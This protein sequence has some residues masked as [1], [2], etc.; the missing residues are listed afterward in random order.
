MFICFRILKKILKKNGVRKKGRAQKEEKCIL[1]LC[2][3]WRA[4][5]HTEATCTL[6]FCFT[7]KLHPSA[8]KTVLIAGHRR[9]K[10]LSNVLILLAVNVI[11]L[12]AMHVYP[13]SKAKG[14]GLRHNSIQEAAETN[15]I[16]RS[17]WIPDEEFRPQN[18]VWERER[19]LIALQNLFQ[20]LPAHYLG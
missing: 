11:K 5:D 15:R 9:D 16:M 2:L 14:M 10:V 18:K 19:D 6:F 20:S 12:L 1:C 3:Q 17:K 4:W 8:R 7:A 13:S